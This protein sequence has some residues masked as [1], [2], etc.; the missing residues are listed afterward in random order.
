[1]YLSGWSYYEIKKK[2]PK[3]DGEALSPRRRT[4]MYCLILN[5]EVQG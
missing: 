3:G 5:S 1:M 4:N 2:Y